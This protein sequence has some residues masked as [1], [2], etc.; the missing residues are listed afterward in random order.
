MEINTK[1]LNA[2]LLGSGLGTSIKAICDS[3]ENNIL[4]LNLECIVNNS[5]G[6]TTIKKIADEFNIQYENFFWNKNEY[7]RNLYEKELISLLKNYNVN[8]VILAGWNHLVS[9]EFIKSFKYVINLHPAL[10]NSY[11]GQNCIVQA[12]DDFQ[13]GKIKFT[14]SMVHHVSK[15][16]DRGEVIC[17]IKIPIYSKDTLKDLG[18][19]QKSYEKGLLI[20]GIQCIISK[21]NDELIENLN[22]QVYV[23]K[24]R[25]VEDIGYN[26]L[27]LSTSDRLSAFDRYVCD[28]PYK[29]FILNQLSN[30]WFSNT[31]D[32]INNHYLYS[33]NNFMV[34]KKT[35]PIKLEI[36]IRAYMTG[37]SNTSIWSMYKKGEREMYG[38]KFRDGYVKNEKLDNIIITPT[39]KGEHDYPITEDQI[40]S[41]NFLTK[42]EYSFIKT[43][44]IELFTRG[45]QI[46]DESGFI[47]VDTKYEFGKLD[48]GEIILI[49]EI[50][51]CDSSRYWLKE[52]YQNKF[53]NGLEPD[54]LDKDCIRDWIKKQCNPYEDNLP[55]VPNEVI[56]NVSNVYKTYYEKLTKLNVEENVNKISKNEFLED[57]F[58]TT[59]DNLVVILAGSVS[60]KEHVNKIVKCLD[61]YNIASLEY[62]SSAHKNTSKVLEIINFFNEQ[63]RKIIFVTVAGLSNALSGVTSCNTH[64][65]VIACPPFKNN[66]DMMVNINST[67]QCPSKVP[68]MTILKP[69]NV[70]LSIHKIFNL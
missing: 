15:E 20:Q 12:Y 42:D 59:H 46:A 41:H 35:N 66:D 45:Q 19:R 58:K 8:F 29:G 3:V 14:G 65:P 67:L 4:N 40:I 54:K 56:E 28:V 21:Y 18:S 50:H 30:W 25:T 6:N 26:L 38:I 36:I 48:S 47:L 51:T 34:V 55:N 32:I 13:K 16:T 2:A 33:K 43:K 9:D 23:G 64:Y 53:E 24:V 39:T 63:N 52:T 31:K 1:Y 5:F 62:Y 49:D 7:S 70:A 44:A 69:L 57:Y 17:S 10:P 60:D 11:I 68:V 37:S 22:K 61:D 27:L